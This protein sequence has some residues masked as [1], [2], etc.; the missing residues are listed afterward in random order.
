MVLR[1]PILPFQLLTLSHTFYSNSLAQAGKPLL[2]YYLSFLVLVL[3]L[4]V[5]PARPTWDQIL[6]QIH[7][8]LLA[9]NETASFR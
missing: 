7:F 2:K 1:S 9:Q 6:D 4:Y 3:V 8:L 5:L